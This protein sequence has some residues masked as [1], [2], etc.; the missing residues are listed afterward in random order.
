M[1]ISTDSEEG[2][3]ARGAAYMSW[4][5]LN[6]RYMMQSQMPGNKAEYNLLP[7]KLAFLQALLSLPTD[8]PYLNGKA[9]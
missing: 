2:F 5:L 6:Y 1:T 9:F 7:K 8:P 4:I 3:R